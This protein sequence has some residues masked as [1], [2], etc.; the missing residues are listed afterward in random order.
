MSYYWKKDITRKEVITKTQIPNKGNFDFFATYFNLM[1]KKGLSLQLTENPIIEKNKLFTKNGF[2]Y[3]LLQ[4]DGLNEFLVL[5]NENLEILTENIVSKI[6]DC[7]DESEIIK[8]II[9][10]M[11]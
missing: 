8:L 1:D 10:Q 2:E 5:P 9:N 7:N 6:N 4:L 11:D 3:I